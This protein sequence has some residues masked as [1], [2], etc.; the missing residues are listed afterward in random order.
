M[1][2]IPNS[3]T[4]AAEGAAPTGLRH[5]HATANIKLWKKH[6]VCLNATPMDIN[7]KTEDR[8][9]TNVR[10][11]APT[12]GTTLQKLLADRREYS[13]GCRKLVR[14]MFTGGQPLPLPGDNT[15]RRC[16]R[17]HECITS[18]PNIP[19]YHV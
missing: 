18:T 15:D 8:L 16:R 17:K 2:P 1:N 14:E 11:F 12:S 6:E 5:L 7:T 10:P 13:D 3:Y 9:N 19:R 4:L